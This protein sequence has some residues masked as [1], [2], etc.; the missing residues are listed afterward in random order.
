MEMALISFLQLLHILQLLEG[1]LGQP[2]GKGALM[3]VRSN[4]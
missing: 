1:E 3:L 2:C 4:G